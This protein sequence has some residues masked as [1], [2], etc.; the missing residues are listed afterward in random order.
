VATAL[1]L[2]PQLR[3]ALATRRLADLSPGQAAFVVSVDASNAAGR[4][5]L[6]LGFTPETRVTVVRR[7][8]LGDPV[9]YELRGMRLCLRRSDA[10]RIRVR[11]P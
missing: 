7:A 8:P 2:K 5:L 9:A 3:T 11:S 1:D 6:D 10:L 4:R